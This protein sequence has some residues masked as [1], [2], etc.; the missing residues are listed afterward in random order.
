ML[1]ICRSGKLAV[2]HSSGQD[3]NYLL[4]EILVCITPACMIQFLEFYVAFHLLLA[5]LATI[6]LLT[7]KGMCLGTFTLDPL[8]QG[9]RAES[10]T[11]LNVTLIPIEDGI[12]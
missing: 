8:A 12:Q 9:S 7:V 4:G 3:I 10:E 2:Y 5:M 1:L 11:V 6:F